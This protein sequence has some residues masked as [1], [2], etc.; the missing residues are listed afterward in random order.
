MN[1]KERK[2]HRRNTKRS[3]KRKEEGGCIGRSIPGVVPFLN[4]DCST[5]YYSTHV[6]KCNLKA[7]Y[8]DPLLL[9]SVSKV[10]S[11]KYTCAARSVKLRNKWGGS[12]ALP[13]GRTGGIGTPRSRS[14]TP[15]AK[16]ARESSTTPARASA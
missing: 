10:H 2:Y 16:S 15:R 13:R 3:M 7:Y 14:K 5:R 12:N 9:L 11:R 6:L 8:Q 4:Q 1:D